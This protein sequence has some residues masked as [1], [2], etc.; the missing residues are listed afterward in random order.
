MENSATTL[1]INGKPVTLEVDNRMSLLDPLRERL[2]LTGKTG[3]V[4]T[5]AA[6]GNAVWHAAGRRVRD[7][8]ITP[9][10]TLA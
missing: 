9:A 4:G 6:I 3:I 2:G 10:K 1:R 5:A 7:L 8:P